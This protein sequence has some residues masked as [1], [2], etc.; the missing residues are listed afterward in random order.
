MLRH[1]IAF[2]VLFIQLTLNFKAFYWDNRIYSVRSSLEITAWNAHPGEVMQKM[3]HIW[4]N[5]TMVGVTR[6]SQAKGQWGEPRTAKGSLVLLGE[7]RIKVQGK[8][9]V[10]TCLA[11]LRLK[12]VNN[13]SSS[14]PHPLSKGHSLWKHFSVLC[15]CFYF[16]LYLGEFCLGVN[17][18]FSNC[19]VSQPSLK[20]G[21]K[22]IYIYSRGRQEV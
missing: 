10:K 7:K 11:R 3:K 9:R 22:K 18:S 8:W 12:C 4:Q 14:L 21:K 6:Q 20:K 5:K 13:P 16:G 1:Y 17:V 15:V 19:S 2:K